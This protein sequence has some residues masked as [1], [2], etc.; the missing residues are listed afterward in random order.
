MFNL[1]L[2]ADNKAI[3]EDTPYSVDVVSSAQV[4]KK[5]MIGKT[6]SKTSSDINLPSLVIFKI[7]LSGVVA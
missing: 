2:S 5:Y 1:L 6:F 7:A 4:L 3:D